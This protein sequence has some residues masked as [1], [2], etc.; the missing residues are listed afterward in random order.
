MALE[1]SEIFLR[2]CYEQLKMCS[3][4]PRGWFKKRL[5][6]LLAF[7]L[8]LFL[9]YALICPEELELVFRETSE[10]EGRKKTNTT[11]TN[12]QN[13]TTHTLNLRRALGCTYWK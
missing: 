13:Q 8:P 2:I 5:F 9:S 1:K 6:C 3:S 10:R 12:K 11:T 7:P 4:F